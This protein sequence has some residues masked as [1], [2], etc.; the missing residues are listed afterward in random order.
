MEGMV[1]MKTAWMIV[2]FFMFIGMTQSVLA[3]VI[4]DSGQ[5][6]CYNDEVTIA[7]P[8]YGEPFYGQD[9]QYTGATH[10]Y[11]DNGDGTVSDL[12]TGLMWSKGLDGHKVT[13]KEGA[14]IAR[15]M[16]LGGYN[17]WRVPNIKELYSLIDFR[18]YTGFSGRPDFSQVPYNAV[19]FINTDYFDFAYGDVRFG[20]RY[21]DAQW[22]SSTHYVSATMD[23]MDTVFGVNFADGRIKGY[24]YKRHG[25]DYVI[26]TFYARY[27][28]GKP[29][30]KNDFVDNR[31]GTITDRSSGLM[32]TKKDSGKAMKWEQA[33]GWCEGLNVAS[34]DDWRLPTAKELQYIVDYS[35]SPDTTNSPAIDPIFQTTAITNEAGQ[36]D[37]SFFWSSTTHLDGPRPG[38]D[39][40][41]VAFGRAIGQMHGRV[42]DVHGAGAQR[43]DLKNG[44][45][46]LGHGP[47]G[48][49]R[50][51]ENFVRCVRGG[52][53]SHP[54]GKTA[55]TRGE[56]PDKIRLVKVE[57]ASGHRIL[58]HEAQ[59][60]QGVE[61]RR[62]QGPGGMPPQDGPGRGGF[63]LRLDRD[64][65]G[66]V[67]RSEFDG[68]PSAFD[69]HDANHDGYLTE[70]EAPRMP[71]P[72][73]P[74]FPVR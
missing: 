15:K 37:F 71:A 22:L 16:T 43:S 56:Y 8:A 70:D 50:R 58:G 9:A 54:S 10:S 29:Y 28:R 64:G 36:K 7:C 42:M 59:R 74:G 14:E 52:V 31:D 61:S 18:G 66:R 55:T 40:A 25:S 45:A 47:Q 20:E 46:E 63:V 6:R 12:N 21:I 68:P 72:D 5:L 67:S 23:G 1:M 60:L 39:A 44:R 11:L 62:P 24:G 38:S 13:P 32:W 48:D 65:D 49:A 41:Y 19:P 3:V 4:P 26:K 53:V 17:D 35:R 30:G 34:H 57:D 27:V 73:G 69:F 33:L 2:A 51:G